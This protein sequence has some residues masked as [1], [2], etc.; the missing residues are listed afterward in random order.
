[1]ALLSFGADNAICIAS[2]AALFIGG[3][4]AAGAEAAAFSAGATAFNFK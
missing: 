3:R 2:S 1:V 4:V